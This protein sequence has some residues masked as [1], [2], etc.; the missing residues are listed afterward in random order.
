MAVIEL[1]A[2]VGHITLLQLQFRIVQ[3]KMRVTLEDL[4]A[5]RV[6]LARVA[7]QQAIHF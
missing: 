3:V 2:P 5:E 1:N 6:F 7:I 4:K